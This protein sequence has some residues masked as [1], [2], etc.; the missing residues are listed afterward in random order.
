MVCPPE[1]GGQEGAKGEEEVSK[2][3]RPMVVAATDS[4]VGVLQ[5]T[6]GANP[7]TSTVELPQRGEVDRLLYVGLQRLLVAAF[8]P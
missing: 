3:L 1:L 8:A 2:E 4:G 5:G 6:V 7:A